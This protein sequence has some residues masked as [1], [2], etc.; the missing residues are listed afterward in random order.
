MSR[1][2][3][4]A[5]H[6]CRAIL[7]LLSSCLTMLLCVSVAGGEWA[8]L[9]VSLSELEDPLTQRLV[10]SAL[11]L[12]SN[13]TDRKH[14]RSQK[15]SRMESFESAAWS[16]FVPTPKAIILLETLRSRSKARPHPATRASGEAHTSTHSSDI[17]SC[18]NKTM[19]TDSSLLLLTSLKSSRHP[20]TAINPNQG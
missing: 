3:A 14:A 13:C 2:I 4:F 9:V 12:L 11:R 17:H 20:P 16:G 6:C 19:E 18:S 15:F 1:P 7:K 10:L 5:K 8:V